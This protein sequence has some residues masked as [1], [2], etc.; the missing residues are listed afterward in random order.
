MLH[1]LGLVSLGAPLP[2]SAQMLHAAHRLGGPDFEA[3]QSWSSDTCVL[4][5]RR[6]AL[7][8]ETRAATIPVI[9]PDSG[10]YLIGS[11]RIDE[12]AE[13]AAALGTHPRDA[14]D[15]ELMARSFARW[16]EA[17]VGRLMG[18]F[19]FALWDGRAG[20][21]TLAK[22]Y[23]GTTP[24]FYHLGDGLVLFGTNPAALLAT[25]LCSREIDPATLGENIIGRS[26]D[27]E[28]T[29]YRNL[30]RVRRASTLRIDRSGCRNH[31]YWQPRRGAPLR[32]KSDVD[33]VEATREILD[34]VLVGH[35]RSSAPLGVMLSGGFDSASIAATLAMLAP[36]RTIAGFTS[37]PAGGEPERMRR[38]AREWAHVEALARRH[39]NIEA[40]AIV[41]KDMRPCDDRYRDLF[42]DTGLPIGSPALMCRRL[43]L[44]EA[45]RRSGVRTLFNGDGGNRTFTSEGPQL[46][47]HLFRSGRWLQLASEVGAAAAFS[48]RSPWKILW[49]DVL[50]DIVPRQLL[51]N[52]YRLRDMP[53]QHITEGSLLRRPFA[54]ES[55]LVETWRAAPNSPDRLRLLRTEEIEP[56]YLN[57]QP[58]HSD[59]MTLAYNRMG[60]EVVAP[61]RDRR[62]IDF[63]LSLPPTQFR[64]GGVPRFLARRV[65]ADRLPAETLEERGYF[66]PFADLGLWAE[67]WWNEA[68]RQVS[69]QRPSEL[70]EQ[71]IDL[72]QLGRLLGTPLPDL[73]DRE[74]GNPHIVGSAVANALH[75]NHF[76]RWHERLND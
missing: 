7:R 10:T 60:L 68:A 70:A 45:A 66:D 18:N 50:R 14:G 63:I 8:P 24:L 56:V 20:Q 6:L 17:G 16:G 35:L 49:R 39:P 25:G 26:A 36:D 59:G 44:A 48:G 65:L 22:D 2:S 5:W 74:R 40:Q 54:E 11:G 32:L 30:R 43:A 38:M 41:E 23:F 57:V 72:P 46:F 75:V 71:A 9:D 29:L 64:R 58:S 76:L 51:Q 73:L 53:A 3:A 52:W 27:P 69:N 67:K 13:L 42:A 21:L 47:A 55:G 34:R 4:A 28:A 61:L 62:L 33:Y 19:G 12:R 31:I 37:V 15:T 1:F